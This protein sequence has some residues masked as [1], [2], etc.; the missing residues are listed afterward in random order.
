M[1]PY[2]QPRSIRQVAYVAHNRNVIKNVYGTKVIVRTIHRT[3]RMRDFAH[4]GD[5]TQGWVNKEKTKRYT[6]ITA[7][8][9]NLSYKGTNNPGKTNSARDA[10]T[11]SAAIV[12]RSVSL[13]RRMFDRSSTV[14][15]TAIRRTDTTYSI[16]PARGS[17][18]HSG[19]VVLILSL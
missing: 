5:I 14:V 13:Y 17:R 15:C 18:V 12:R 6:S 1:G 8:V 3:V 16:E 7:R 9:S 2:G 10:G 4:T 19:N 11:P